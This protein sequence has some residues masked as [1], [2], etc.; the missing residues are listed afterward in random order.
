MLAKV[1][2]LLFLA[3]LSSAGCP[4]NFK[5]ASSRCELNFEL[6]LPT[7]Q[8]KTVCTKIG[9][10]LVGSQKEQKKVSVVCE[11]AEVNEK[12]TQKPKTPAPVFFCQ[13]CP[14]NGT[15]NVPA[16][17]DNTPAPG[18][19]PTK[20]TTTTTTTTTTT[21]GVRNKCPE[22]DGWK[23][24]TGPK[25]CYKVLKGKSYWDAEAECSNKY[26]GHLAKIT[27]DSE[28]QII[29]THVMAKESPGH[30]MWVGAGKAVLNGSVLSRVWLSDSSAMTG[31][32]DAQLA[33][34]TE[35]C[36]VLLPA[37]TYAQVACSTLF[38][39]VCKTPIVNPVLTNPNCPDG[40]APYKYT[41]KCY[42][43]ESEAA[44]KADAVEKCLKA[45]GN[46]TS[47]TSYGENEFVLDLAG[48]VGKVWIG[49]I[50]DGTQYVWMD[51]EPFNVAYW[52]RGHIAEAERTGGCVLLVNT[53]TGPEAHR[54]VDAD[55][56]AAGGFPVC[57]R[58]PS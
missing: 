34:E 7:D 19:K 13:P 31:A 49:A 50:R 18:P 39:A 4:P 24:W 8:A 46:L 29:A 36:Y 52:A 57:K 23:Q 42:K 48:T 5:S 2:S 30:N 54:W 37:R 33:V 25:S 41:Q 10:K 44:N 17:P 47:V 53:K 16:K 1:L 12:E 21:P 14:C 45:G 43:L 58:N 38:E 11:T 32:F 22:G 9:A 56:A 28:M 15:A 26:D 3:G 6:E 55:C 20:V 35:D 51:K 27:D 40:W